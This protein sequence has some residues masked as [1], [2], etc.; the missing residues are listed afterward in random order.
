MESDL[1]NNIWTRRIIL[2]VSVMNV[3]YG[4]LI[5]V[6]EVLTQCCLALFT[7]AACHCHPIHLV[8]NLRWP[9]TVLARALANVIQR[10]HKYC[11]KTN[12]T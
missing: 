9:N 11:I 7:M 8:A 5:L 4:T 10:A 6:K 2:H 3:L 12:M 1:E